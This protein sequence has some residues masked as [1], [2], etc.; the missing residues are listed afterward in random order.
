MRLIILNS[1]MGSRLKNL[2]KNNPK[3][4]V[5]LDENQTIFSRAVSILSKFNFSEIIITTGYLNNVLESYAKKM[6]PNIT[7]KFVYNP[8]Y[9]KTNY[10]KSL[11]IIDDEFE[12]DIVLL[13][14]DL[15]FS[16][17]VANNVVN[18]KKSTVVIDSLINL[19]KND[20][21]AKI[22]NNLV[23]Y[24][25]V[26]YFGNSAVAC[27]PF[28]KL[29]AEDWETWKNKI[30]EYCENGNVNVYA[31]TAL[32]ELTDVIQLNPLDIC[33]DLCNEVDTVEDLKNV[34]GIL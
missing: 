15:V 31:E 16:E 5:Q 28:Y 29:L 14:G 17:D 12:E 6:F 9:D 33:G 32:N 13:H 1:G 21:K 20:F 10:I 18:S 30:H 2:T 8:M 19:P 4:L 7:F 11:D 26:D 3:A 23:K 22:D 25:G 27:Q 24:I 34:K